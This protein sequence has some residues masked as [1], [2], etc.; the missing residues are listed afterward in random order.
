MFGEHAV[1]DA[2]NVDHHPVHRSAVV[3]EPAVQH[4]VVAVGDDELMFVAQ[5]CG[6]ALDEVEQAGA[7]RCVVGAVLDESGDQNASAP[8]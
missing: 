5:L 2:Q 4:D 7:T 1:G 3:G 6:Q 8:A